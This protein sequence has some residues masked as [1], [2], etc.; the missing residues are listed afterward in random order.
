M[1]NRTKTAWRLRSRSCPSISSCRR[2]DRRSSGMT[3][4]EVVA[5]SALAVLM[6]AA[7]SGVLKSLRAQKSALGA[8]AADTRWQRSLVD[9]MRWDL[10]NSRD[11]I[12][13]PR[14]LQLMGF[15]GRDPASTET[16]HRLVEVVYAVRE[17]AGQSC[18]M[19][20]ETPLDGQSVKRGET[21]LMAVGI[22]GV[23]I[24]GREGIDAGYGLDLP[25]FRQ[26]ESDSHPRKQETPQPD[27]WVP[28][29][30]EFRLVLLGAAREPI[31][32][33]IVVW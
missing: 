22:T 30:R 9:R 16:T 28:V 8:G 18:L 31:V 6:M 17:N 33:E 11:M 20:N 32:D 2:R 5:A 3:L 13:S 12:T 14:K 10:M 21:E 7:I 23:M 1:F 26:S 19:R 24:A 4:I 29:P 25:G 27:Q 15:C